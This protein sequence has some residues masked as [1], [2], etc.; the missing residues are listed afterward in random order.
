VE[1]TRVAQYLMSF[2]S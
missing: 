1:H 2:Y